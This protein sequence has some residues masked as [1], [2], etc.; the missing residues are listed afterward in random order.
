MEFE[1][2]QQMDHFFGRLAISIRSDIDVQFSGQEVIATTWIPTSEEKISAA[3]IVAERTALP[4]D[5]LS[6]VCVW[7]DGSRDDHGN[8]GAAVA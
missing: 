4:M 1:T 8:V 2:R 5:V 3:V 6:T 7:T